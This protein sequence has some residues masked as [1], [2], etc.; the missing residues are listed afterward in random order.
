MIPRSGGPKKSEAGVCCEVPGNGWDFDVCPH[1]RRRF[2]PKTSRNLFIW[3]MHLGLFDE[4]A[5]FV[6]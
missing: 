4:G 2:Y 3:L 5:S 1:Y 6:V